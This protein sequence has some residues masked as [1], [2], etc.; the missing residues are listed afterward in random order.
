[1]IRLIGVPSSLNPARTVDP[2]TLR[3]VSEN[4]PRANSFTP[5]R[6]SREDGCRRG[7]WH[8]L[9]RVLEHRSRV[10]NGVTIET[11]ASASNISF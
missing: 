7:N 8:V 10:R 6:S 9:P 11:D 1:M 2:E 5:Y 3:M 4:H